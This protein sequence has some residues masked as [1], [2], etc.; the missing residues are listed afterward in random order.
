VS[1]DDLLKKLVTR[2]FRIIH[3]IVM[4]TV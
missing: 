2:V 1:I 3:R 4:I